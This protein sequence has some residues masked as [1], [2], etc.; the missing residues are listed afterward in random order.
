[1][2]L[3]PID[4][5]HDT[6]PVRLSSGCLYIGQLF[7]TQPYRK[8]SWHET[9][10]PEVESR[11]SLDRSDKISALIR[12]GPSLWTYSLTDSP[13]GHWLKPASIMCSKHRHVHHRALAT[14]V[15]HPTLVLRWKELAQGSSLALERPDRNAKK[16]W[17]AY[18]NSHLACN[19]FV[20]L[21]DK[22]ISPA[23]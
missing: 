5:A 12:R 13:T 18:G 10:W 22:Y 6:C 7:S 16:I 2:Y 17:V 4:R 3:S 14:D 20:L 15:H 21:A 23:H 1:M 9:R 11:L 19:T 8:I